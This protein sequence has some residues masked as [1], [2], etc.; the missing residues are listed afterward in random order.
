MF[1][2]G[3]PDSVKNHVVKE[4]THEKSVLRV[5]ICTIAFEMG[6]DCK[7]VRRS[8]HFGPPNTV[9]LSR[10]QADWEEM[11]YS[12]FATFSSMECYLLIAIHK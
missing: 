3:S 5:L 2:A 6:I 1:H 9:V 10:K 8:I 7:D 12:V 11:D 4:M